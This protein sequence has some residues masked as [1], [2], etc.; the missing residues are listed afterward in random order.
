[1]RVIVMFDLP[2][3]TSAEKREYRNFQKFLVKS[4][5]IMQQESVY[6]KLALNTTAAD[7]I[8]FNIKK[9]K[10]AAGIVQVLTITE[11]Q[12]GRME[13]IVG[14][15]HGDVIDNDERLIIL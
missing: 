7:A 13:F 5:F 8:I 2:S 10:P 15:K 3:I 11:K 6:S 4:G 14:E 9:N 1:M 12:Y